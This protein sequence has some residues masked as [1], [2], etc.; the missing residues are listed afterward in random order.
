MIQSE[1]IIARFSGSVQHNADVVDAVEKKS[2][3]LDSFERYECFIFF[4][5]Y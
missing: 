1:H 4:I 3:R 2:N 5:K